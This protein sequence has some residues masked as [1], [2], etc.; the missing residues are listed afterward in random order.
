MPEM[1]P[2]VK[3]AVQRLRVIR[4]ELKALETEEALLRDLILSTVGKW[5][6]DAFPI[7]VGEV[8]LSLQSRPGRVD[9]AAAL[10]V[11]EEAGLVAAVPTRLAVNEDAAARFHDDL[12]ALGLS[13]TKLERVRSL[14]QKVVRSEPDPTPAFL[15]TEASAG[16]LRPDQ[17]RACF[18]KGRPQIPVVTVR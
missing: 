17:Y 5:P 16:H 11:L 7:R 3:A 6:P 9:V 18:Q 14:Y 2:E 8:E 12:K 13:P 15:A 10:R 4:R 1:S